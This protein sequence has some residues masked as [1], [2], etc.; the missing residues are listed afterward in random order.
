MSTKRTQFR[1]ID[2]TRDDMNYHVDPTVSI[3]SQ[4]G[5]QV[6]QKQ[7]RRLYR[8]TQEFGYDSSLSKTNQQLGIYWFSL[9]LSSQ[10]WYKEKFQ[11]TT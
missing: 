6:L 1:Q 10:G 8:F 7:I 9:V 5:I 3:Q 2:A 4:E 11:Y